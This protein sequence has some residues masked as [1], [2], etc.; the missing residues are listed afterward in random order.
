ME[1]QRG[2]S[3]GLLDGIVV[4]ITGDIQHL[5]EVVCGG[6]ASDEFCC[7]IS[8]GRG[9]AA[10][11]FI[12]LLVGD[13]VD[14]HHSPDIYARKLHQRLHGHLRGPAAARGPARA[15]PARAP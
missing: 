4:S 2:L 15:R 1:T 9:R 5:V 11:V 3:V 7:F 6:D 12:Y 8:L 13:L 10:L 14:D